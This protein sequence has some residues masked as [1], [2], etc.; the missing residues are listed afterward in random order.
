M[1]LILCW[2]YLNHSLRF[3]RKKK[4]IKKKSH[5][6]SQ[7]QYFG[8]KSQLD[9]FHKSFSPTLHS[10]ELKPWALHTLPSFEI[11]PWGFLVLPPVIECCLNVIWNILSSI[12]MGMVGKVFFSMFLA[13]RGKRGW[14]TF[15]AVLKGMILY[16]QK[17]R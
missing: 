9:Y 13:P 2:S 3:V 17:V 1:Y 10:F 16:L 5:I 4:R 11:K 12:L 14:K 7:S 8:K 15:Y 6:K